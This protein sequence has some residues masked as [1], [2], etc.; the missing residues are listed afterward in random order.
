MWQTPIPRKTN[1]HTYSKNDSEA[2]VHIG[3]YD[4]QVTETEDGVSYTK[5]L[6]IYSG[7]IKY[8]YSNYGDSSLNKKLK[9][10]YDYKGNNTAIMETYD[11]NSSQDI[12]ITYTYDSDGNNTFICDQS[13]RYDMTYD[14][15]KRMTNFEVGGTSLLTNLYTN[16]ADN[17]SEED[18][19]LLNIGDV[20]T[21]DENVETYSNSTTNK[22]QKI[23]T[24]TITYKTNSD[25]QTA[26]RTEV[27]YGNDTSATY[28]TNMNQDGKILSFYDYSESGSNPVVYN[29]TYTANGQTVNRSDDFTKQVTETDDAVNNKTTK[30]TTYTFKDIKNQ[31][32]NYATSIETPKEVGENQSSSSKTTLFND[33]Y[34]NYTVSA[35][36]KVQTGTLMSDLYNDTIMT[37]ASSKLIIQVVHMLLI[38]MVQEI[39][40]MI[41]L[42]ISPEI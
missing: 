1:T 22:P 17:S 8:L 7:T 5:V 32:T 10:F 11:N 19:A 13:T 15:D 33:D 34:Y 35:D 37:S 39:K 25:S 40:L 16:Y 14:S 3:M 9:Y 30:T 29:Y 20:V 2:P 36:E 24:K 12:V 27:Y 31:T 42:M 26:T 18:Y 6:N 28:V 41:T 21:S 23:K 4:K 38:F